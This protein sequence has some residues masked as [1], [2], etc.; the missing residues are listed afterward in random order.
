VIGYLSALSVLVVALCFV[1]GARAGILA[2]LLLHP[3]AAA[4]WHVN[5][6]L[7]GIKLNPLVLMGL[8]V[9][10]F[11]FLRAFGRG[12]AFNQM[13]LFAIWTVY[14]CYNIFAGT[15]HAISEG[16]ARSMDLIFRHIAGFVG[17]YMMQ[18]FFT[19]RAHFKRLLQA[20]VVSGMFPILVILYQIATGSGT[21]REMS[22]GGDLRLDSA[23]GL[24]RYSG[25]FHDI[26]SVRGYVFQCL[27]GIIL[28]WAYF[29]KPNR[30]AVWKFFL[31]FLAVAGLFVLY[32]MYSKAVIGTLLLWFG[33]WS[34]GYRKL[35]V[36][37]ALGLLVVAVNAL[38]SDMIFS[39]TGQLFHTE[40]EEAT[41][42]G[43]VDSSRLLHGR[44][45][46]WQNILAGFS[47]ASAI[48]QMVGVRSA[49]GAHNDFLQKLI[50]GG[51][52]GLTI[53]LVLLWMIGVRVAKLYFREKTPINLMAV[54]IFGGWMIDTIGVVPSL[55]PGYQWY[56]WGL[57]GLAIKGLAF[58]RESQ[59]VVKPGPLTQP[60]WLQG[61]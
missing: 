5:Y 13:P 4:G 56:A 52:V 42:E 11:V 16:P 60:I 43:D 3:V 58:E 25:F 10:M 46:V 55:Y 36:G 38:Q 48:E 12:P 18:A 51:F 9:P 6:F 61:K 37:I 28:Y 23:M 41:G 26:V 45:G 2:T 33:I 30:D 20:L 53:Y 27:A 1:F 17:F 31:A 8:I 50:Y 22:E 44:I 57:I 47:E 54:M 49:A 32:K 19:E 15:L 39:E 14:L 29:L 40:I 24:I 35:G 21:L 34:Y 59:T 7:G